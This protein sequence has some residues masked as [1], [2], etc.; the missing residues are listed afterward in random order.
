MLHRLHKHL[1]FANVTAC[2]ALFVALGG[3]AYA[4]NT[5][6]SSDITDGQ[7]KSV[8]I[9]DG[10]IKSADVKDQSLTTFDVS[11]F[12]G[13]DIVDGSLT[14][15]DIQNFSLGNGDFLDGSVDNRIVTDNSLTGFDIKDGQIGQVDIADTAINSAKVADNSL[16]GADIDESTLTL[17][18]PTTTHF[19][20]GISNLN[21]DQSFRTLVQYFLPTVGSYNVVAS[22]NSHVV[23]AS[24]NGDRVGTLYCELR[25]SGPDGQ[26]FLGAATDRRVVP[27]NDRIDRTMTITG[28]VQLQP[29]SPNRVFV[30]CRSQFGNLENAGVQLM[31][32]RLDGFF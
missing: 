8:D 23:D 25:G 9:G 22:I 28:G 21:S 27:Q 14:T 17:P 10:E 15:D 31:I 20:S 1:S 24:P 6:N 26:G 30:Q 18:T 13:A 4:V 7:V 11:T 5:V 2:L 29:G 3:S 19:E 12:L 16:K 32:T